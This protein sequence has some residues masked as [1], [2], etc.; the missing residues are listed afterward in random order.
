MV[1]IKK[2]ADIQLLVKLMICNSCGIDDIQRQAVDFQLLLCYNTS[3][4]VI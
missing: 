4:A 2:V 3:K 1:L